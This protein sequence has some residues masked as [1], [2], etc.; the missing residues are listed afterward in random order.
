MKSELIVLLEQF[1][2]QMAVRTVE[3]LKECGT[4]HGPCWNT[5]R[6]EVWQTSSAYQPRGTDRAASSGSWNT[7][8]QPSVGPIDSCPSLHSAAK[9]TDRGYIN[10]LLPGGNVLGSMFSRRWLQG[11]PFRIER[12][13]QEE[14]I[15]ICEPIVWKMWE[16]RRLTALLAFMAC[17]R[18]KKYKKK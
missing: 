4:L 6:E 2:A 13:V 9:E 14:Y 18:D 1:G 5:S 10:S 8:L 11:I 17:Y 16:P 12:E 7:D 3:C 15:A